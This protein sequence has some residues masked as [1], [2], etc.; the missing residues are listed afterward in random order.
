MELVN[1][2][3]GVVAKALK[4]APP[5]KFAA[6]KALINGES[7]GTRF[8]SARGK[9]YTYFPVGAV[10]YYVPGKLDEGVNYTCTPP[11]EDKGPAWAED[12]KSTYVPKRKPKAAAD[13]GDGQAADGGAAG[14]DPGAADATGG[15]D[16]AGNGAAEAAVE[17]SA[18]PKGRRKR[19]E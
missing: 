17:G 7:V 8:T 6:G 19:G 12:R 11:A 3:T 2:S 14:D 9:S 13:G 1:G 15:A 16:Q 5:K 18:A 4:Y 10:S